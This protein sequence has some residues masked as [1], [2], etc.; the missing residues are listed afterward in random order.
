MADIAVF[1]A[2]DDAFRPM[3]EADRFIR[4]RGWSVGP[5]D[6]TYRR[7]VLFERDVQIAK[8]KNLSPVERAECDAVLVG[9]SRTG[10]LRL[11]PIADVVG[12]PVSR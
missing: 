3:A 11:V 5:P 1:P 7:G 9:S 6:V 10:P 8:W 2:S 4:E 12:E